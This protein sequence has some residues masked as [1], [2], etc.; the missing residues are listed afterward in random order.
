MARIDKS[1]LT[2]SEIVQEA[3]KQFL[4]K[5][6][7]HTTLSAIS[8]ELEMSPGNLTFHFPTKEHLL[9]ELVEMLCDFRQVLLEEEVAEG[10]SSLM[11]YCL[12][13]VTT[14]A[15]SDQN[16]VAKDFFLSA[17]RSQITMELLRKRDK[18]RS[19]ELFREFC[20]DWTDDRFE[21]AVT[22]VSGIKYATLMTTAE[23][24]PLP[25]RITGALNAILSIYQVPKEKRNEKLTKALN[26]DYR[27]LSLRIL[28][29]FREYVD[30]TTE[31]ALLDLMTRK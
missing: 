27:A 25:L 18:I 16:E 7:S 12:E 31:Q 26:L 8:K 9:A 15:A 1:A 22:L 2:K 13:L 10:T 14:A 11:A 30:R 17:Y 20:P 21:E 4:E 3:S 28:K 5:G 19:K 6:Y 29:E 23:S 24:A